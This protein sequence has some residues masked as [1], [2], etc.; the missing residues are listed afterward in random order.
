M[1]GS[2]LL[3]CFVTVHG[4]ANFELRTILDKGTNG[5]P[6]RTVVVRNENSL[7]HG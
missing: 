6:Y 3:K 5:V 7:G 4:F 2:R 1:E